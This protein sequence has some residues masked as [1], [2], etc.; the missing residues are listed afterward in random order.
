MD[1]LL[2]NLAGKKIAVTSTNPY[3]KEY[4]KD[5]LTEGIADYEV[6]VTKKDIDVERER[7]RLTHLQEGNTPFESPEWELDLLAVYRQI[8]ERMPLDNTILIHGSGI[9]VD[10]D[11]YLFTAKSGV[12]KSTHTRLWCEYF[13]ERAMMVNDDKPLVKLTGDTVFLHG[14]PWTGKH[15]LGNPIHVPLKAICF[16]ER[17]RTNQIQSL[18]AREAT[19]LLWT[20]VYRPY[21]AA[22]FQKTLDITKQLLH[23]VR[24][25]RLGCNMELA[26]AKT[27]YE[28][29]TRNDDYNSKIQ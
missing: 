23:T 11:G 13:G 21:D 9:S 7:S 10:G 29:I 22:A 24:L 16:L 15:R 17:S 18:T 12:G 27:A 3:T 28:G 8:A 19:P 2:L 20:Q 4:C 14:T 26:A 6:T 5:Y 1:K 25:Y